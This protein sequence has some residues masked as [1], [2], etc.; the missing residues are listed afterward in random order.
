[1]AD[2]N[3]KGD[4]MQKELQPAKTKRIKKP[5]IAK[6]LFE[7]REGNDLS[8]PEFRRRVMQQFVDLAKTGEYTYLCEITCLLGN[9]EQYF[10]E[11]SEKFPELDP[12]YKLGKEYLGMT[13]LKGMRDGKYKET[14]IVKYLHDKLPSHRRAEDREDERKA[15]QQ[16]PI[17]DALKNNK[18]NCLCIFFNERDTQGQLLKN[19]HCQLHIGE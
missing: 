18:T 3:E 19:K 5:E 8:S 16:Q 13:G 1:M 6:K 10:A 9:H 12:L 11:L 17:A 7:G 14:A 15:K 4:I 2:S